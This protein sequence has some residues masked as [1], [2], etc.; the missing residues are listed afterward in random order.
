MPEIEDILE[1]SNLAVG[2]L[3]VKILRILQESDAQPFEEMISLISAM[4]AVSMHE[5]KTKAEMVEFISFVIGQ[6]PADE[7]YVDEVND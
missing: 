1:N 7:F 2:N 5:K 4:C 6:V 3:T